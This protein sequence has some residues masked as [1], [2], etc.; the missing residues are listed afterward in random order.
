MT[1]SKPNL[2]IGTDV[3]SD[4]DFSRL[5]RYSNVFRLSELQ[6]DRLSSLLPE[7]ECLLVFS[8]P[9]ELTT[10]RVRGMKG[11]RFVQSV[12]AGVNHIPFANLGEDVIVCSNAGA[13]SDEVAEYAWG[14]LLSA[15]KRI[16]ELHVSL[17]EEKWTLRR[18]LD[19]GTEVTILK[20]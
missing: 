11:L 9:K 15:A 16:V 2:L 1:R 3:I 6:E 4:N 13:Y 20:D 7:S 14:L 10:E 19:K 5:S 12:L 17:R 18:T 8:W